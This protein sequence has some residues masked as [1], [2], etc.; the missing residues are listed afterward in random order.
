M[1]TRAERLV[2]WNQYEILKTL[3]PEDKESYEER[4]EILENGYEQFYGDLHLAIDKS[5]VSSNETREVQDILDMYRALHNSCEKVGYKPDG[6]WATFAGFDGNHE[7]PQFG[8]AQFL[9]R[10]RGL[11]PELSDAP[12]D[13]HMSALPKYRSML[14]AWQRLGRKHELSKVEINEIFGE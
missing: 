4:Q 9:R 7:H 6:L 1:L 11:W 5:A 3:H 10:T 12:D 13:S 2:L 14:D 8:I